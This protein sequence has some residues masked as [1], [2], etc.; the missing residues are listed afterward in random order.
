MLAKG[1]ITDSC[2][3]YA[4]PIVIV[5]KKSGD[6]RLCVDFR[7]LNEKVVK[8]AFPIPRIDESLEALRGS[9][10]FSTLDLAS[11]Y[12]QIEVEPSD[13][14]KTAFTTPMGLYEYIRMP[15][16]LTNAAATFSR[17]MNQVLKEEVFE[18]LLVYLDDIII[19][20]RNM[21]EQI[22][23]LEIVFNK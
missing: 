15:F 1:I 21:D 19:F 17:L 13:R 3:N 20:G 23:R 12:H 5:Y 7:R 10:L 4:S 8:D 6:I 14:C 22:E 18:I 11:A 9:T 16:G 2:S